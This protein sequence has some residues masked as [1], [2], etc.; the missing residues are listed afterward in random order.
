MP[1]TVAERAAAD[2]KLVVASYNVHRW[3]GVRGG[4]R[5]ATNGVR[6]GRRYRVEQ[7]LR[8]TLVGRGFQHAVRLLEKWLFS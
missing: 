2:G 6:P 7:Y 8:G 4:A 1:A 3:T 5:Y